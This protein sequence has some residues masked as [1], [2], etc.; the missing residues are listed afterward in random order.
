MQTRVK[1]RV[2]V[3]VMAIGG[4]Y[5]AVSLSDTSRR[6]TDLRL[7]IRSA[8]DCCLQHSLYKTMGGAIIHYSLA[9]V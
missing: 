8:I 6:K 1:I 9:K 2:T 3:M 5:M 7:Q 4:D